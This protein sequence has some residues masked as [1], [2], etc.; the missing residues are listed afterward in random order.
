M[1][2]D[3]PLI[4]GFKASYLVYAKSS[5]HS[6]KTVRNVR[7]ANV[8]PA[9]VRP[10][11]KIM[12]TTLL[13]RPQPALAASSILF[14]KSVKCLTSKC[15]AGKCPPNC[16]LLLLP[17]IGSCPNSKLCLQDFCF[18]PNLLWLLALAYSANL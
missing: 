17:S 6:G 2:K 5:S 4:C 1:L 18:I 16:K 9:N 12:S 13:L 11:L 3:L 15:L 7:P 14:Y 10:Q 8:R